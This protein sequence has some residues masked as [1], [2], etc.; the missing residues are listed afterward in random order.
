MNSKKL[1]GPETSI[2]CRDG[3]F[4]AAGLKPA[5]DPRTG[6]KTSFGIMLGGSSF[7]L[8][9]YAFS[10]EAK[11]CMCA[12]VKIER[13]SKDVATVTVFFNEPKSL[14]DPDT[15]AMIKLTLLR[16]LPGDL[17]L[18]VNITKREGQNNC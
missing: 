5:P 9:E 15:E 17:G 16:P 2:S 18:S 14:K 6:E 8:S 12:T 7:S 1:R 10:F 11:N 3:G 13:G 4:P